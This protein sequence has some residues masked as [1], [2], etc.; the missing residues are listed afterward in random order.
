MALAQCRA[1]G[2]CDATEE[3]EARWFASALDCCPSCAWTNLGVLEYALMKGDYALAQ[4]LVRRAIEDSTSAIPRIVDI[5]WDRLPGA[6]AERL[7]LDALEADPVVYELFARELFDRDELLAAD[8]FWRESMMA[9]GDAGG[10]SSLFCTVRNGGFEEPLGSEPF[11]WKLSPNDGVEVKRVSAGCR[12]GAYC[13][14]L[15]FPSSVR[16]YRQIVQDMAFYAGFYRLSAWIKVEGAA[17]GGDAGLEL[18]D[19]RVPDRPV[20]RLMA[21]PA[22]EGWQHVQGVFVVAKPTARFRLRVRRIAPESVA[23]L[24]LWLDD[25]RV[26]EVAP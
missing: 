15:K 7:V 20:L 16:D 26:V 9:A 2:W 21:D 22:A 24:V 5:L 17:R 23:D 12:A 19:P 3:E 8:R 10:E 6:R 13:L 11:G 14:E 18:I 4:R 25:V 1:K